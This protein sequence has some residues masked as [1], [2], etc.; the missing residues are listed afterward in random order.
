MPL[1]KRLFPRNLLNR[2]FGSPPPQPPVTDLL[3]PAFARLEGVTASVGAS[4]AKLIQEAIERAT[5]ASHVSDAQ[6]ET[7][8]A[9]LYQQ[10]A[11]VIRSIEQ[12]R[13]DL[14]RRTAGVEQLAGQLA[15][16]IAETGLD[17]WKVQ[18][19][20]GLLRYQ[21]RRQYEDDLAAGRLTV[22]HLDT[23]HPG[24][25]HTPDSIHPWGAVNDNSICL[26]FN[27]RL[28]QLFPD[29]PRLSVLDLGCAG[30][31]FVRSLLDDGHFAVGLEGCETPKLLR[32]GEWGTIPKHLFSCDVTKPFRLS[33]QGTGT[34]LRFH[35][36]TMWEVMEHIPEADLPQLAANV[37]EHL[38]DDGVWV[39]SVSTVPDPNPDAGTDYHSTVRPEEWWMRRFAELGFTSVRNHPIGRYDWLRGA[40][41]CRLDRRAEDEG[42]G[43]HVVLRRSANGGA[44]DAQA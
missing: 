29:R 23:A 31:G 17:R 33:E 36:I 19:L 3:A 40:G 14:A 27:V 9:E 1:M 38:T 32:L 15:R 18:E 35:A 10:V 44:T 25:P 41:N 21:R 26:R 30:G 13:D 7:T 39:C 16:A 12:A 5:Q 34:P 22:P 24:A 8:R 4:S 11:F 20:E 6:A 28:A 42:I 37:S 43:F 2:F